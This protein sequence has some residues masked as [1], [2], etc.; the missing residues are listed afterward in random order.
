VRLDRFLRA[1]GLTQ[2]AFAKCCGIPQCQVS[3][4]VRGI[5]KPGRINA[6]AISAATKGAIPV[7]SWDEPTTSPPSARRRSRRKMG[8]KIHEAA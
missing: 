2:T 7:D 5:R 8:S 6:L 4:Y 3:L 1:N